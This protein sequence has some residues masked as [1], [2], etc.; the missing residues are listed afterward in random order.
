M[1]SSPSIVGA[2]YHHP[3]FVV[4]RQA[5]HAIVPYTTSGHLRFVIRSCDS[6]VDRF[7]NAERRLLCLEEQD[8]A[9][10]QVE[11]DEMLRF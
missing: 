9:V 6:P 2:H 8:S 3:Q 7:L 1:S 10:T 5:R 11:V 4:A